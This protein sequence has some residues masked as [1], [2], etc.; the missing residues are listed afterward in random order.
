MGKHRSEVDAVPASARLQEVKQDVARLE[1]ARVVGEQAEYDSHKKS[2]Q[3][4]A[5]VAR[6]VERVVEPPD[7]LGGLDVRRVLIAELPALDAEDETE[8]LDMRGQV[9]EGEDDDLP[10]VQIVKLEGLEVAHQDVA[11]AVALG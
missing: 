11:R 7:Q 3:V 9:R 4:V 6:V 5:L 10:L 2:F 8:R 1:D